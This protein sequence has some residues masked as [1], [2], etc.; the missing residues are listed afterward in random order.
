MA[1][2]LRWCDFGLYIF[3]R[4]VTVKSVKEG[5][6][7]IRFSAN[8]FL[9]SLYGLY[10]FEES[11]SQERDGVGYREI[12]REIERE[13]ERERGRGRERDHFLH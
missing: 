1:F 6:R 7:L 10:L 9:V 5:I 11:C 4:Y 13:R 2:S 3:A 12:K 8:I